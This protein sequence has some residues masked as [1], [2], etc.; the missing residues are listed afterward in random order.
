MSKA[1]TGPRILMLDIETKPTKAYVWGLWNEN[2]GINQ[3]IEP[4]E[5][6]S[7]AAKWHGKEPVLHM[8]VPTAGKV[9]MLKGIYTLL[10]A[11]DIVVHWNGVAF[12]IPTL[13]R[14]FINQGWPPPSPFHEIDLMKTAKAKFK[15]QSNKFDFVLKQLGLGEKIKTDFDLWKAFMANDPKAWKLMKEYNIHDAKMLEPMYD[16][17]RPWVVNHPNVNLWNDDALVAC[18]ICGSSNIHRRGSYYTATL[19]YKRYRCNNC[20]TWGRIKTNDLPKDKKLSLLT[21]IR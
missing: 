14:E 5:T 6:I 18:H 21:G 19:R 20:G 13:N 17:M 7:W 10:E 3:I 1:P 12:D 16:R 2:I 11:A 8:D 15:F 9:K 4:G